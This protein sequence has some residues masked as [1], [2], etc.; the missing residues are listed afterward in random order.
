MASESRG[1]P[2]LKYSLQ[3]NKGVPVTDFWDDI[4]LI[5]SSSTEA[6]GYPTQ[7]PLALLERIC[8]PMLQAGNIPS[9]PHLACALQ[10]SRSF[11]V[12]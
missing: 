9:E 6:L 2:Q 8:K 10:A 5:P 1:L 4:D 12:V 11:F 7:K 3:D